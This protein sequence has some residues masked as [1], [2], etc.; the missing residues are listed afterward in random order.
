MFV[1]Y[2]LFLERKSISWYIK[3]SIEK[4]SYEEER[5]L[6]TL[7]SPDLCAGLFSLFVYY[8]NPGYGHRNKTLSRSLMKG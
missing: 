6:L 1:L 2:F 4:V 8:C 7:A 3:L 5:H